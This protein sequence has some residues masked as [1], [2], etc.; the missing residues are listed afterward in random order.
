[1]NRHV[2]ILVGATAAIGVLS[3]GA[4]ALGGG[5]RSTLD[6]DP[7]IAVNVPDTPSYDYDD[8]TIDVSLAWWWNRAEGAIT[9]ETI[10]ANLHTDDSWWTMV[11][12]ID[13]VAASKPGAHETAWSFLS[14]TCAYGEGAPYQVFTEDNP[15][16]AAFPDEACD[17]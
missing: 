3:A 1:M 2:V 8:R 4:M 9:P 5:H 16:D 13:P 12:Q 17:C 6:P 7:G 14:N 15:E 10:C 11:Q